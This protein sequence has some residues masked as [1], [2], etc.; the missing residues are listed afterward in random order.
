MKRV[1][2]AAA[3]GGV[4]WACASPESDVRSAMQQLLAEPGYGWERSIDYQIPVGIGGGRGAGPGSEARKKGAPELVGFQ[5]GY[6]WVGFSH[7]GGS[8]A[9]TATNPEKDEVS[10]VFSPEEKAVFDGK[11]WRETGFERRELTRRPPTKPTPE[12][13]RRYT[14]GRMVAYLSLFGAVDPGAQWRGCEGGLRDFSLAGDCIVAALTE[15][16][17]ATALVQAASIHFFS[18]TGM[19]ATQATGTVRF[20]LHAGRVRRIEWTVSG[21]VGARA[22]RPAD[23]PGAESEGPSPWARMPPPPPARY[24]EYRIQIEFPEDAST[25]R[26]L[27]E[28]LSAK[29]EQDR[30]RR[31]ANLL[32]AVR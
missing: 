32:K 18:G 29:A 21:K 19:D 8:V 23:P 17:A 15:A 14:Q 6:R 3:M 25:H 12:E 30:P 9:W 4:T 31:A 7:S 5:P 1:M 28:S 11:E 2:M 13:H 26:N 10:G 22:F 16:A 27:A 24:S 20:W